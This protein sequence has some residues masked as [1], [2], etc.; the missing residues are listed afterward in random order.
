VCVCVCQFDVLSVITWQPVALWRHNDS[1]IAPQV[2]ILDIEVHADCDW[3]ELRTR[4]Q[5]TE[6]AA[7]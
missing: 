7:E 5:R 1:V 4:R 3:S 6:A 2:G